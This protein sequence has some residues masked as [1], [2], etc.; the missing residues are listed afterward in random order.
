MLIFFFLCIID[1][2]TIH[3]NEES[4]NN[5]TFVYIEDCNLFDYYDTPVPCGK[6]IMISTSVNIIYHKNSS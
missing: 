4:E 2:N 5:E 1:I 6:Y 3:F